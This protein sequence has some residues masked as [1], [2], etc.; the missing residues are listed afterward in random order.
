MILTDKKILE[1]IASGDIM[2]KPFYR[3]CLGTNSYDVHLGDTLAVYKDDVLDAK[4]HNE[5]KYLKIPKNGIILYPGKLYLGVTQ[6]YTETH[7][8]VPV[9]EGKCFSPDT[10]IKIAN[11][12]SKP[13]SDIKVGDTIPTRD[14]FKRVKSIHKG[15]G[16]MYRVDQSRGI[17][18]NVNGNHILTLKSTKHITNRF[19]KGIH[20]ISVN[21]YIKESKTTRHELF[22]FREGADFFKKELPIDPYILGVWLGDGTISGAIVSLFDGDPE[23]LKYIKKVY[24]KAKAKQ[25]KP[26][27]KTVTLTTHDKVAFKRPNDLLNSLRDMDLIDNKHIPDIYLKA[28]Y[29]QRMDLLSGLLDT[30]GYA[31]NSCFE[32]TLGDECLFNNT[33]ELAQSLGFTTNLSTKIVNNKTYYRGTIVGDVSKIPMKSKRKMSMINKNPKHNRSLSR[34]TVTPIGEGN[35]VG[36][37]LESDTEKGREFFLKDNTVVHNSSIGRLGIDIHATAGKGDVGFCNHWTLEISCIQPVRIY[38]GMPIGQ[39]IYFEISGEIENYYNKKEGAKY[40][41]K[42]ALPLESMMFKNEF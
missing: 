1:N 9:I 23:I 21:E 26:N 37:E 19:T 11:G 38:A 27:C 2:I 28:S 32:I 6:E 16:Q 22:G 25:Y 5:V 7:K 15:K 20:R 12:E 31:N 14:G 33:M 24:P 42:N 34:I 36:F 29:N 3:E 13:I 8:H 35:Y 41:E 30:D 10:M 18:Y 39:L 4:K 40:V 17:S